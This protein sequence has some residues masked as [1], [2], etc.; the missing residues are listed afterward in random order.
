MGFSTECSSKAGADGALIGSGLMWIAPRLPTTCLST[1]LLTLQLSDAFGS[2]FAPSNQ[3]CAR[4][5]KKAQKWTNQPRT[6]VRNSPAKPNMKNLLL[7]RKRRASRFPL[8]TFQLL[9]FHNQHT[10]LNL[11]CNISLFQDSLSTCQLNPQ[12]TCMNR[13]PIRR[14]TRKLLCLTSF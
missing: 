5:I 12:T 4:R 1:A 14:S 6:T 3:N 11:S 8:T 9:N 2:S 7:Q 13:T 10:L